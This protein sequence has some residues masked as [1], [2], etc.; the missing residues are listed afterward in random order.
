MSAPGCRAHEVS[1][2]GCHGDHAEI[3][4]DEQSSSFPPSSTTAQRFR[5]LFSVDNLRA[6]G[7]FATRT[8]WI[9]DRSVGRLRVHRQ[10][11]LIMPDAEQLPEWERLL[12]HVVEVLRPLAADVSAHVTQSV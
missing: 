7:P 10:N 12:D 2:S 8:V 11:S 9:S 5:I 3:G 1:R 4:T 6:A